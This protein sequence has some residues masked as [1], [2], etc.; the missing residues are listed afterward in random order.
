MAL[1]ERL[2]TFSIELAAGTFKDTGSSTINLSGRR[3]TAKI[4]KAG[5]PSLGTAQIQIYGLTLSIA[6]QL[7]TLGMVFQLIPRNVITVMAGDSEKGMAVAF[8]GTITQAFS[9]FVGAPDVPF[10]IQAHTLGAESAIQ[11]TPMSFTGPTD[12]AGAMSSIAKQM[13]CVFEN[14][15]VN[16]TIS[17]PYL[18]GSS[19]SMADQ[20]AASAGVNWFA[21]DKTLAIWPKAGARGG[22]VPIIAP[23]PNGSMKGYPT[24]TA[25]GITVQTEYDRTLRFG[26]Q[27]EV[28]S[29]LTPANKT[30]NIVK[31][32]HDLSTL[33]PGGEWFSTVDCFDPKFPQPV[34]G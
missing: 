12:V 3:A 2:L 21:D 15:G 22:D 13:G 29:S 34:L 6:N 9:S 5:T 23:P 33:Y 1:V 20:C 30:W 8:V 10:I 24:F 17:S 7:S 28:K 31:L 11:Q 25:Y 16:E 14:N 18:W 26:A 19:R 27:V 4:L 32:A